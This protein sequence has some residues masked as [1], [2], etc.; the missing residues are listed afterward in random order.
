MTFYAMIGLVATYWF[1]FYYA[2]NTKK[3]NNQVREYVEAKK[4]ER[5][6]A[7]RR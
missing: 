6:A 7:A 4:A 2:R 3:V 1:V 5:K